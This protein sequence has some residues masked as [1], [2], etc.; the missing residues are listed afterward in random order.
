[1]PLNDMGVDMDENK[2]EHCGEQF[3]MLAWTPNFRVTGSASTKKG[4][5]TSTLHQ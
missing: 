4:F 2:E 5:S 3:G 1:M